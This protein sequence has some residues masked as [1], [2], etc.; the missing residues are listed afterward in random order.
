MDTIHL[1]KTLG[2]FVESPKILSSR[3]NVDI[4]VETTKADDCG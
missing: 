4:F 2:V 1:G 3:D